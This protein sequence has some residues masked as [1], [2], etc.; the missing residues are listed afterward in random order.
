MI[1]PVPMHTDLKF[2]QDELLDDEDGNG[3]DC[4]RLEHWSDDEDYHLRCNYPQPV[5]DAFDDDECMATPV[6]LDLDEP[7]FDTATLSWNDD[8]DLFAVDSDGDFRI[9]SESPAV[10]LGAQGAP[11]ILRSSFIS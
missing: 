8:N 9:V 6:P 1:P 4:L 3:H 5:G 7:Q 10:F 2:P 11:P